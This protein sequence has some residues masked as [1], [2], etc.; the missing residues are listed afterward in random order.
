MQVINR[1]KSVRSMLLTLLLAAA[2]IS[3]FPTVEGRADS[4]T[5]YTCTINRSYSHPVT[6]EIEDSG[7]EASY[8]T[9]QGM[10]ESCVYPTGILEVTD[11]NEYYLTF[12]L[13]LMDVTSNQTFY[14]QNIGDSGWSEPASMGQTGSGSDGNGTTA[15][16]CVQVPSENCIVRVSLY[17]EP[18]ERDVIFYFY[19][20]DYYE[21]NDTD[22]TPAIV[23]ETSVSDISND[24]Q[25]ASQGSNGSVS[26]GSQIAAASLPAASNAKSS[27]SENKEETTAET[28]KETKTAKETKKQAETSAKTES[29]SPSSALDSAKGLSLSTASE[30]TS[31]SK[32]VS[33]NTN[34]AGNK[35][36]EIAAAVTI[37]GLIL[38]IAAAAIIYFFRR[39][40]RRWG[41]G[42]D[43]DE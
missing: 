26:A 25:N 3:A 14:V 21:G 2:I 43:D 9:G 28:E 5:V 33:E 29:V 18:M 35:V 27:T 1:K 37:S 8:A 7:G 12:K 11:N 4:G 19:P 40:W 30:D 42:E 17:V 39:N 24:D 22:M 23:T 34:S 32:N 36:F 20:S 41:G 6:G 10:V 31:S 13:S 15:D 38:M 16:V